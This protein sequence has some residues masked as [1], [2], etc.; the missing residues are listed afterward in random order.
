LSG[1]AANGKPD[2]E[3]SSISASNVLRNWLRDNNE[4][5]QVTVNAPDE[6]AAQARE[7]GLA[8]EAYVEA[9]LAREAKGAPAS[10]R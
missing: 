7:K 6:F 8:V 3:W 1:Q 9:V 2:G 5:I 10:R 4:A